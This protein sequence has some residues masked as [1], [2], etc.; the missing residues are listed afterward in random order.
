MAKK[1]PT[2]LGQIIDAAMYTKRGLRRYGFG[3]RCIS[4]MIKAIPRYERG[5]RT[6]FKGRDVNAWIEANPK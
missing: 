5:T 4:Q 6:F 2:E 1:R 3:N